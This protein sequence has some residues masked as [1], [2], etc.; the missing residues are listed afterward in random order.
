[1]EHI[2]NDMDDLFRKAG[3]LYPLKISGSDWEG[4]AGK[5]QDP[6]YGDPGVLSVVRPKE[7]IN[8][9]KWLLLLLLIPIGVGGIIFYS[10][11]ANQQHTSS[12]IIPIKSVP[13]G[14][15]QKPGATSVPAENLSPDNNNLS[16]PNAASLNQEKPKNK[17]GSGK[18]TNSSL[19]AIGYKREKSS[20][21]YGKDGRKVKESGIVNDD[22]TPVEA[23]SI[24]NLSATDNKKT[25]VNQKPGA[26]LASLP[27]T[28]EASMADK[29]NTTSKDSPKEESKNNVSSEKKSASKANSSR[30]FYA[31]I[32]V[33]PDVSTVKFQSVNQLGFSLGA[34]VGYKFNKHLAVET[35]FLWDKKYYHTRGEYFKNPNIYI[36]P[37]LS[38]DG[39]CNMLEIPVSIRYNFAAAKNH[40]FFAKAGLSSYLGMKDNYNWISPSSGYPVNKSYSAPSNIFSI[41]Q[42]SAGYERAISSKIN[43]QV[44]PYVKIPL[45]GVGTGNMPI[46]SFG[47]YFGITH[48]F[49]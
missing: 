13:Q 39:N 48:S 4:V 19:V 22:K 8:R 40:D 20:S 1:M 26:E 46:S 30:G 27:A 3:E 25:E 35:G 18:N 38:I 41:L 23:N 5:L 16:T 14:N 32:I 6:N 49:R 10:N 12:K 9:R 36:P 42:L 34:I 37:N 29:N 11:T 7:S 47:I 17:V 44:E 45:Q 28:A 33:G 24:N 21:D 31:G 2:D 15:I 43:V